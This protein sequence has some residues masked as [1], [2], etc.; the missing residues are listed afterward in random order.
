MSVVC[1]LITSKPVHLQIFCKQPSSAYF[2]M[3]KLQRQIKKG[4]IPMINTTDI[5]MYDFLFKEW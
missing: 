1:T 4:V 3:A 2:C 5:E